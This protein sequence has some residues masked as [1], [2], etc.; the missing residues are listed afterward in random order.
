MTS[1]TVPHCRFNVYGGWLNAK[2]PRNRN[3]VFLV[4]EYLV[5]RGVLQ[6]IVERDF[7]SRG[8]SRTRNRIMH[9]PKGFFANSNALLAD[10]GP[11]D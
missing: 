5:A 2:M 9:K 1:I 4:E 10:P 11:S 6:K 8:T 7:C 3:F